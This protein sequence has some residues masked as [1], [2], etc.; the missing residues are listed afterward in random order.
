MKKMFLMLIAVAMLGVVGCSEPSP[1]P[2]IEAVQQPGQSA[3]ERAMQ[4]MPQDQREKYEQQKQ[5]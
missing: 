1:E 2:T 5:N 3:M 4:G